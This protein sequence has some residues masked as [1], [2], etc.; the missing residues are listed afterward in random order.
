M[1]H[2]LSGLLCDETSLCEKD[3]DMVLREAKDDEKLNG[4]KRT[5]DVGKKMGKRWWGRQED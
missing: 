4:C 3:F 1:I 5:K 2:K